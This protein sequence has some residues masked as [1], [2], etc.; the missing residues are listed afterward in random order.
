MFGWGKNSLRI[1]SHGDK[2]LLQILPG[3]SATAPGR[4]SICRGSLLIFGDIDRFPLALDDP[5]PN[6]RGALSFARLLERVE[7]FV[8]TRAASGTVLAGEAVQ[9]ALVSL[10]AV[11]MA[12]AGLLVQ[13][14]FDLCGDGVG[15]LYDGVGKKARIHRFGKL[16]L[17]GQRMK[18][19]YR[20]ADSGFGCIRTLR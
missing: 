16:T 3:E 2:K 20:F 11:A 12:V 7:I 1:A 8:N 4:E 17:R 10:A 9:E 6:L 15:V 18:R 19:R 13:R 5:C 14:L